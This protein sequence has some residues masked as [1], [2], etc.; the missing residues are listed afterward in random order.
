MNVPG[1]RNPRGFSLIELLVVIIVIGI[2][3]AIA[4]QSM[5]VV[6][7]DVRRVRTER[8]MEM[9]AKAIV[10]DP[11]LTQGALRND[12]GYV[13]DVGA[14]PPNLQ[15]LYQNTPGFGTWDGPYLPPDFAQDSTGFK[16]DEWG[17]SYSYSGG[18][19]ISS[20]GS[21]ATIT[22][23]IA[24]AV[25]DYLVN[26]FS[27]VV[28]DGAGSAP[29]ST[30]RDSVDIVITVP[31]GT[32]GRAG[33]TVRPNTA[34]SFTF[35]SLPVGLHPLEII[36]LPTADTLHRYTTILPRHKSSPLPYYVFSDGYFTAGGG[37]GGGSGCDSSGTLILRPE[38]NGVVTDLS[39][40]G[41]SNNWEC[42]DESTADEDATRVRGPSNF[43]ATDVYI[44]GDPPSTDCS[45]T[46]VTVYA[47]ARKANT[48]GD[49]R[50]TVYTHGSEYNG[51]SQSLS[52]SY[53]DY[54]E[55]WT[56]NPSTGSSW[57]WQEITDFQAGISIRGQ[58]SN[59]P[60]YCTQVWVEVQYAP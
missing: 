11:G 48:Q 60:A 51:S 29:G 15:A 52:S 58:S 39:T 9:L 45:I 26:S 30:Y 1:K 21:G 33:R 20:T 43:W 42:V 14:F 56:I 8:E 27:G 5:D 16:M 37:G 47:R 35:D 28:A 32:G 19:T 46:S 17:T 18:I 49:V 25:D 2:L 12:F 6:V 59:F 13:G 22:R 7:D 54:S 41:C 53:A 36:Y 4:M 10:G 31:D 55:Q 34:G 3:V 24:D 50:P 23:K 44:L 38:G 40:S 57:T